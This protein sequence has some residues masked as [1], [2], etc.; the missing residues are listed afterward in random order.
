VCGVKLNTLISMY[1]FSSRGQAS[2]PY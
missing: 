2:D 1:W